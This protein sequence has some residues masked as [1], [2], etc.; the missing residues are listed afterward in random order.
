MP[1]R[2]SEL[3]KF[4]CNGSPLTL[5]RYFNQ[6][7]FRLQA[8]GRHQRRASDVAEEA[9]P[10]L[11]RSAEAHVAGHLQ[12]EYLSETIRSIDNTYF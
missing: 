10:G 1:L 12:G 2:T 5:N 6:R 11:H 7:P 8:Q 3:F 9:A 4:M